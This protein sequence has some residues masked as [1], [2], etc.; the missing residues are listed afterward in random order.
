MNDNFL[1][2]ITQRRDEKNWN[3]TDLAR[4]IGLDQSNLSKIFNKR[5]KTT[6]DFCVKIAKVFD[7]PLERVLQLAGVSSQGYD[8]LSLSELISVG[9]RL[10]P[11]ERKELLDYADYLLQKK[12]R[13]ASGGEIGGQVATAKV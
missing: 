12:R 1:K 11:E 2:W 7:E 3:D 6:L 5:R 8:E 9:K 4:A 10:S 13:S